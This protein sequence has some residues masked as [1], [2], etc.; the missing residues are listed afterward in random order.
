MSFATLFVPVPALH[1]PVH[2]AVSVAIA[3]AQPT[4]PV[5]RLQVKFM[6]EER[7]ARSPSY[8]PH[9]TL[10]IANRESSHLKTEM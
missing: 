1:L 10:V 4:D 3:L 9:A 5:V 2:V 7:L 8:L 6:L